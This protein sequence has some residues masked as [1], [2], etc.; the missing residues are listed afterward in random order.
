[1]VDV[2]NGSRRCG[3]DTLGRGVSSHQ[4]ILRGC[5]QVLEG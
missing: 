5:V 3:L 1:M 4:E 2:L